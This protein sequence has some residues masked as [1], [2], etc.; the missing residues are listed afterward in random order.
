MANFNLNKVIIG[1][2]LTADPELRTTN[3][4]VA[5]TSF[6]IAVNGV[7]KNAEPQFFDSVAWREKAEF[8]AKYFKKGS[9]I[10][11][12]GSLKNR[13]WTDTQGVKQRRTEIQVDEVMFVD[14]KADVVEDEPVEE[15]VT[16][17]V[18]EAPKA[19]RTRKTTKAVETPTMEDDNSTD[20]LPF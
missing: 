18:E 13:S 19:K 17:T 2:R 3:S 9:N 12:T 15:V 10:C 14:S 1:G 5:T 6:T 16:E 20:D 11:I 8:V 4:G 7:G